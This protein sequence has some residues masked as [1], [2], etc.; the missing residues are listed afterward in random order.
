M[1][2]AAGKVVAMHYTLTDEAGTVIDTS[3]GGPPMP[4]LHGAGNIIPGLESQLTG[5]SVGEKLNVTVA[6]EDAYGAAG[7][8]PPQVVPRDAFP[9]GMDIQVGMQFGAADPSGNTTQVWVVAVD[10]ASVTV[11]ANHPLAGQ[12]LT[13]AIEIVDVR[14]ASDEEKAHGHVHGVGGHHH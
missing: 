8:I 10:D 2:I 4:F 3:D 9:E 5:H 12:T 14:D 11:T 7:D 1:L 6:P 13:F